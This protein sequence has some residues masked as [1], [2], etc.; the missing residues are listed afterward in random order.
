M[1]VPE[2]IPLKPK[3]LL[4]VW[5]EEHGKFHQMSYD[6]VLSLVPDKGHSERGF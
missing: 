6:Y 2:R 1:V 3:Q 5:C 4:M